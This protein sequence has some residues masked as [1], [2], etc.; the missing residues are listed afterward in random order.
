MS[1]EGYFEAKGSLDIRSSV[2][3]NGCEMTAVPIHATNRD[4]QYPC[5]CDV[6]V[7]LSGSKEFTLPDWLIT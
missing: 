3:V 4:K 6:I 1:H 2:D 5:E 7:S